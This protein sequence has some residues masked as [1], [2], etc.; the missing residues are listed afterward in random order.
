MQCKSP[1]VR[2]DRVYYYYFLFP[3]WVERQLLIYIWL[4]L[5]VWRPHPRPQVSSSL[6]LVS[7]RLVPSCPVL[8]S[9]GPALWDCDCLLCCS[10][11]GDEAIQALEGPPGDFL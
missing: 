11:S 8:V 9:F 6:R 3:E 5:L 10:G 7:S 4:I 1:A 2:V